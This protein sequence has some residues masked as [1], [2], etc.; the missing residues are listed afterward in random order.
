MNLTN[1]PFHD[2]SGQKFGRLTVLHREYG[3]TGVYFVCR[4]DCGKTVVVS[5]CH[6]VTGHTQRPS[7]AQG[8][9]KPGSASG[10]WFRAD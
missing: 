5:S 10:A 2:L 3:R 7:S 6:L 4:C 8:D 9:Q 1:H